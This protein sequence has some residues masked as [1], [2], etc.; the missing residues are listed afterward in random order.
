M[1]AIRLRLVAGGKLRFAEMLDIVG[2]KGLALGEIGETACLPDLVALENSRITLDRFHQRAGLGLLG[3]R[4]LAGAAAVQAR[5]ELIDVH[6]GRREIMLGKEIG[7][8]RQIA[9]HL[10]EP[11]HDAGQRADMLAIARDRGARRHRTIAAAGHDQP[12]AVRTSIGSG[13]R[14][15]SWNFFSPQTGHCGRR[16]TKCLVMVAPIRSKLAM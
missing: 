10:L 2:E 9:V 11:G 8:Q 1:R 4:A 7:I 6:G 14:F 16:D 5:A 13:A 15:G 12:L 3:G